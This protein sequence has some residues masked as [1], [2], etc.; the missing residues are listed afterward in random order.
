MLPEDQEKGQI[1][2]QIFK[3]YI[4][5]NGG[6]LFF[7]IPIAIAMTLW[8][9]FTTASAIIMEHWC[10]DPIGEGYDLYIYIALTVTSDLFIFFRA[11]KLVIS[12]AR[13]GQTVHKKMMKA[14]LYASLGNFFNR[15]PVGRIIN[16]LTKDLRELD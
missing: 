7:A 15:V 3:E 4:K 8:I 12:G 14:L 13:Q 2:F 5:F 10:E 1:D 6:Y 11:Y 9:S 16:R